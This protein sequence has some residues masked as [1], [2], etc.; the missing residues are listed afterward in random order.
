MIIRNALIC[1]AGISLLPLFSCVDNAPGSKG[2][3]LVS[4]GQ[5][6]LTAFEVK[7]LIPKTLSSQDSLMMAESYV[8]KWVKNA[9]IYDLANKH[10]DDEKEEIDRLVEA[11]RQSLMSHKYEEKLVEERLSAEISDKEISDYYEANKE[12]FLLEEDIVKGLFLKVPSDAPGLSDLKK[13]CNSGGDDLIEKIEKY[14][15]QNAVIY[16]YF[17][18]RWM[19]GEEIAE[20]LPVKKSE[21]NRMLKTDKLIEVSDSAY[22]H[23]L[24]VKEVEFKGNRAP[25]DY[26]SAQIKEILLSQRK[27]E[28]LRNFEEEIYNEAI[29]KGNVNFYGEGL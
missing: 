10:L 13:W 12:S 6:T 27:S 23:L 5:N 25:F 24:K 28:F 29:R 18:D 8:K 17:Y 16:D 7:K 3:V 15:L 4:V 1:L 22:C 20:N 14:S 21:F 2:D 11:Y 26:A 9:L 19:S